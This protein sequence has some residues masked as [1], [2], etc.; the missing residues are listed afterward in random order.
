MAESGA[1][2]RAI[3]EPASRERLTMLEAVRAYRRWLGLK[4]GPTVRV[5]I[6]WT[7]AIARL[8]AAARLDPVTTTALAQ[9]EARLTGD[10]EGFETV[11]GIRARGLSA[12][13]TGRPAESQDLWHAR[14]YLVRPIVRMSLAA[15]WLISGLLG[16]FN[17]AARYAAIL[18]PLARNQAVAEGLGIG[19]GL[20]DLAIAAALMTGWR[21]KDLANVQLVMVV[22]YTLVL[23][24]LAPGLWGDLVGGLL[25]NIPLIALILVRRILEEER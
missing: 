7:R 4:A 25:K 2:K 21:L 1:A 10:A 18:E 17:D 22:G 6:R 23:T 24:F 19:T 11:T 13:L 14:L 12:V 16:L 3:L 8:G 9:F 5:P 20:M 15:L